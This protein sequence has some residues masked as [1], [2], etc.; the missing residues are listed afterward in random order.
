MTNT[1]KTTAPISIDDLKKYFVDKETK[2]IIDYNNSKLQGIKLLTYL[3]NLDIPCDIEIDNTS[4]AFFELLKEYL[5]CPFIVNINSLEQAT[6]LLLFSYKGL[7][8]TEIFS[9]FIS[10]NS[11][12]ISNWTNI[13]DSCTIYNMSILDCEEFN[14]FVKSHPIAENEITQ[15]INFVSLLKHESFYEFYEIID[16]TKLKYYPRYFNEYMFKGKNLFNYWAT[17]NNPLFLLTQGIAS[18][19]VNEVLTPTD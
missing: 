7:I 11:E 3:S 10:E 14:E 16:Q 6:I 13:L 17:I 15:G 1:I 8:Q 12:I 4:D 9:K 18:G 19:Q 5:H 2:Y